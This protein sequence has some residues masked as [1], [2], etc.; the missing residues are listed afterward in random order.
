MSAGHFQRKGKSLSNMSSRRE[1]E[2]RLRPRNHP[3][4]R[5]HFNQ[6]DYLRVEREANLAVPSTVET[7]EEL[8]TPEDESDEF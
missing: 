2:K 4:K 3:Y 8:S 5:N 1:K 7:N 6:T